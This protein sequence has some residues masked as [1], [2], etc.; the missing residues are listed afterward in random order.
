MKRNSMKRNSSDVPATGTHGRGNSGKV[1]APTGSHLTRLSRV[2]ADSGRSRHCMVHA[3]VCSASIE[4]EL[5]SD[6]AHLIVFKDG[7]PR[8]GQDMRGK[9]DFE[10]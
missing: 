10:I 6:L 5:N 8:I 4:L 2:P 7:E 9:R 3:P 1:S